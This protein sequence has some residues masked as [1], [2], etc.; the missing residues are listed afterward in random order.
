MVNVLFDKFRSLPLLDKRSR[1][2]Q[3]DQTDI[4]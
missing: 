3:A 4:D 1:P 2:E